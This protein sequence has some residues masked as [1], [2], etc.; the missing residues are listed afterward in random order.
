M[1][2]ALL[3]I[4]LAIFILPFVV[5]KCE[6]ELEIFLFA[7]GVVAVTV[8]AE[9]N[10]GLVTDA[11]TQPVMITLAVLIAGLIFRLLERPLSRN[12]SKAVHKM[13]QK[14]F[15]FLLVIFLGFVSCVITYIVAALLLV[16]II[17]AIDLGERNKVTLVVLACYSIG[18]GSML[19]P[20]GGPLPTIIIDKLQG[21][22]LYA[23]FWFIFDNLWFYLVPAIIFLGVL[24]MMIVSKN[25][26]ERT[27]L[28]EEHEENSRE[29]LIRAAKIYI[30]IMGLVFIGVGFKPLMDRF[31]SGV[32]PYI[33][34]WVN[35]ASAVLDN[36]T[37]AAAEI[38]PSMTLAQINS[39]ML[40]LTIA[41][42]MLIPGN[43]PNI[44]S[45]CKLKIGSKQWARI[46]VPLGVGIML[47]YFFVLVLI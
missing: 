28:K 16:E 41:G 38:W 32:Q 30:F 43:I 17:D 37:L 45:A 1:I 40:G 12:V 42:G 44:I 21:A 25:K 39:A 3:I 31:V 29:I 11:L 2:I 19:T 13:G 6:E 27:N 35:S 9:W 46:G 34:Y 24:A 26:E 36:A 47:F 23:N 18:F 20:L 22:P 10:F 15:A 7:M 33:L 5:K 4:L 14:L 8:T